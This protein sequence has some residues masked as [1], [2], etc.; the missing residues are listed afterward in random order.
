V[1]LLASLNAD[2]PKTPPG[3]SDEYI[4][5]NPDPA[6]AEPRNDWLVL[7]PAYMSWCI[8]SPLRNELLVVDHTIN[9]LANF[10]RFAQPEPAHLNFRSLCNPR[11]KAV[12][13]DFLRWCLS[14]EVLV[15]EDQVKRS[16]KRWQ[17]A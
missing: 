17:D 15:S 8:R 11:Q 2:F 5:N 16:L 3:L 12:V 6:N 7:M 10:G 9:A 14:E 1:E 4:E 13:T